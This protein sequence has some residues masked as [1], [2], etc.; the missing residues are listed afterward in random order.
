MTLFLHS[1]LDFKDPDLGSKLEHH[2][3]FLL[4][5]FLLPRHFSLSCN[6]SQHKL[7]CESYFHYPQ[8]LEYILFRHYE[9]LSGLNIQNA[10][11]ITEFLL[12]LLLINLTFTE[13]EKEKQE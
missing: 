1:K 4:C 7:L 10:H 12:L 6:Y 5:Y 3:V 2:T 11:I 13:R 8:N 9:C